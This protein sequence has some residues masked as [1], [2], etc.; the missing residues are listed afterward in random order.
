MSDVLELPRPP[1]PQPGVM[2][3]YKELV[4]IRT[5]M[6]RL[7]AKL[8]AA[9]ALRGDVDNLKERMRDLEL[10]FASSSAHQESGASWMKHIW[11][12]ALGL[13]SALIGAL[14]GKLLPF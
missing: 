9:L 8:D 6:V 1:L 4:E 14:G 11:T 2:L 10:K 3:S 13:L 7:N 5:E 12:A